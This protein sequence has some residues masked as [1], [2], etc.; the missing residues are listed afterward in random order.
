MPAEKSSCEYVAHYN[1]PSTFQVT[2]LT[3]YV[4]T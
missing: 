3:D 4:S 1:G 2:L